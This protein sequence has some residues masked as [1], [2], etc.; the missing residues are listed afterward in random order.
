M[1]DERVER[2]IVDDA[3]HALIA[4][5]I[6]GDADALSR[7]WERYRR[8]VA[9]ILLA[10]KPRDADVE[11]LLQD[12]ALMLTAK[13]SDV[14]EPGAFKPWLRAVALSVAK[15]TGRKTTVRRKGWVRLVGE[16]AAARNGGMGEEE[17]AGGRAGGAGRE[18]ERLLELARELP[19]GYGEPLIMK[20]VQGMSYREIG[21]VMGLPES[22]IETRIARGRRMLRER[23]TAAGLGGVEAEA[24]LN[25]P[26]GAS[27]RAAAGLVGTGVRS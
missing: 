17:G 13:L 24:A 11:D 9:A 22:T 7:A 27:V 6:G 19:E 1:S 14:R 10:H 16:W 5:A 2:A 18:A 12:V 20:A 25:V 15:A 4:A 21:R 23:A 3:E 8:W 26:M